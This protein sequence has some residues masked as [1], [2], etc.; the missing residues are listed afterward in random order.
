MNIINLYMILCTMAE[1]NDSFFA[2]EIR[3]SFTDLAYIFTD[4][5]K[6]HL[7]FRKASDLYQRHFV[8]YFVHNMSIY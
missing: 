8:L 2:R 1:K 7:C 4:E 5:P 6:L 3:V